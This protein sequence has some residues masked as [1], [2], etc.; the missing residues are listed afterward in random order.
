MNLEVSVRVHITF[1][2]V[3]LEHL[4][5]C[6]LVL[7]LLNDRLVRSVSALS[8]H[9]LNHLPILFVLLLLVS[10]DLFLCGHLELRH[11]VEQLYHSFRGD[12]HKVALVLLLRSRR[13]NSPLLPLLLFGHS[14]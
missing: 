9:L 2:V 6:L 7:Q 8:S 14:R 3:S 10:Q 11:C 4:P 5:P 1:P 12:Q 13:D